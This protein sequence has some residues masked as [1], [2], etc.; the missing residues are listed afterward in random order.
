MLFPG[1]STHTR[2]LAS[3]PQFAAVVQL[4]Q[5]LC[6]EQSSAGQLLAVTLFL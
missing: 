4:P 5:S 2:L 1:V 3:Q 6:N